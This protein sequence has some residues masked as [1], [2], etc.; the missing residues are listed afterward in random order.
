MVFARDPESSRQV[1]SSHEGYPGDYDY[2]EYYSDIGFDLE[3]DYIAPHILDGHIRIN[4]GIKYH[5]VTGNDL[6]KEI[7]GLDAIR[8]FICKA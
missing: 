4:T 6:P 5:R 1:W 7:Y 2:R 3:M 8:L